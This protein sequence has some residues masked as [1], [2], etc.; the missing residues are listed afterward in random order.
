M[1]DVITKRLWVIS[2]DRNLRFSKNAIGVN[3][4]EKVPDDFS[5]FKN[6]IALHFQIKI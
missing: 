5:D 3:T 1:F 2:S 4:G 6:N